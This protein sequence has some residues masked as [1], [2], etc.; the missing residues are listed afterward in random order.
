MTR[1]FWTD[2]EKQIIIDNAV[3]A[4]Q[5]HPGI[6]MLSLFKKA[7][8]IAIQKKEL[9][10]DRKRK[11][12][13][14]STVPWF[15]ESVKDRLE[16]A[17]A[18]KTEFVTVNKTIDSFSNEEIFNEAIRR[19]SKHPV[20]CSIAENFIS[21]IISEFVAQSSKTMA[22]PQPPKAQPRTESKKILI[23]GPLPEQGLAISN[24]FPDMD[25]V[26]ETSDRAKFNQNADYIILM[27][28]FIS[29]KS[30]DLAKQCDAAIIR[31]KGGVSSVIEAIETI[32][33]E[34]GHLIR[35]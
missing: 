4:Y 35:R 27:T 1:I 15:E 23:V 7:Q 32:R 29:H 21:R 12:A 26:T 9:G 17:K 14:T 5:R 33:R 11:I 10:H 3:E 18:P 19:I 13:S 6:T 24:K 28:K 16:R 30:E 2:D 22:Q 25:I 8:E 34:D 31:V 20:F